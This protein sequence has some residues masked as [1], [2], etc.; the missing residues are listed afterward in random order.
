MSSNVVRNKY[1]GR[2]QRALLYV[3]AYLLIVRPLLVIGLRCPGPWGPRVV[4]TTPSDFKVSLRCRHIGAE[5][6]EIM[7]VE[8]PEGSVREY[9]I[10]DTHALNIWHARIAYDET[11]NGVWVESANCV[12]GSLNLDTSEFKKEGQPQFRWAVHGQGQTLARLWC[13]YWWE[14]LLPW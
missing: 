14:L 12:V 3:I 9:V 8:S 2:W 6:D 1:K 5:T 11:A 13:R 7:A 4:A 10:N